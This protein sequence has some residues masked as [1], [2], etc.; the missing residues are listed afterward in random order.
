MSPA[1]RQV[2]LA[3]GI[4]AL[5]IGAWFIPSAPKQPPAQDRHTCPPIVNGERVLDNPDLTKPEDRAWVDK[6]TGVP[7]GSRSSEASSL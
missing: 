1:N 2:I 6:C 7:S 3:V 5:A 4:I